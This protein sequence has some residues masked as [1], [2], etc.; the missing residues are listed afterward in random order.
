MDKPVVAT[1]RKLPWMR[2]AVP[3]KREEATS[4]SKPKAAATS[5]NAA[6]TRAKRAKKKSKGKQDEEQEE[7]E[8]K[9]E[10]SSK[11]RGE[12]KEGEEDQDKEE[13]V[14]KKPAPKPSTKRPENMIK[15]IEGRAG[16]TTKPTAAAQVGGGRLKTMLNRRRNNLAA[17][18]KANEVEEEE[19]EEVEKAPA[20]GATTTTSSAGALEELPTQLDVPLLATSTQLD[21]LPTQV[22]HSPRRSSRG[23]A[24]TKRAKAEVVASRS[25]SLS[26]NPYHL[27][28]DQATQSDSPMPLLSASSSP[29][30]TP[31]RSPTTPSPQHSYLRHLD[32]PTQHDGG[33]P[34]SPWALS[35]VA[36]SSPSSPGTTGKRKRRA[37]KAKKAKAAL[38]SSSSTTTTGPTASQWRRLMSQA[39]Q[40]DLISSSPSLSQSQSQGDSSVAYDD[41]DAMLGQPTQTEDEVRCHISQSSDLLHR[42]TQSD[43]GGL[44]GGVSPIRLRSGGRGRNLGP[45]SPCASP[46]RKGW[47][48]DAGGLKPKGKALEEDTSLDTSLLLLDTSTQDDEV[49]L[50]DYV[51]GGAYEEDEDD[52][53]EDDASSSW[54]AAS[55]KNNAEKKEKKEKRKG[56]RP[57]SLDS[58]LM[59]PTQ[60]DPPSS[61]MRAPTQVDALNTSTQMDLS[62]FVLSDTEGESL[63]SIPT[64]ADLPAFNLLGSSGA[65]LPP[66]LTDDNPTQ[67]DSQPTQLDTS[68]GASS[69]ARLLEEQNTDKKRKKEKKEKTNSNKK[70]AIQ[71]TPTL[72]DALVY[73]PTPPLEFEDEESPGFGV[74]PAKSKK[75]KMVDEDEGTKREQ[76]AGAKRRSRGEERGHTTSEQGNKKTE[77]RSEHSSRSRPGAGDRQEEEEEEYGQFGKLVS[78]NPKFKSVAIPEDGVLMG[79]HSTC[80]PACRF[81]NT[82]IST[83]HCK[84]SVVQRRLLLASQGD[85]SNDTPSLELSPSDGAPECRYGVRCYRKNPQHLK[86]FKHPSFEVV[87]ED[88]STNG[89]Y[90]NEV[91]VGRGATQTLQEGQELS[92]V[93]G[94]TDRPTDAP[95][96]LIAYRYERK[97]T[98]T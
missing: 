17:V 21:E 8:M 60:E 89:T 96:E 29:L 32:S 81:K 46:M 23:R 47:R 22:D 93:L 49:Y 11:P 27:L 76:A 83:K 71:E 28:L 14:A 78:L 67:I 6:N 10:A 30:A 55:K 37:D 90:I 86:Q 25:P 39:T 75:R 51:K 45:P 79:R 97:S 13:E 15:A 26:P 19:E 41:L 1:T 92:L 4:K 42:P 35:P 95:F 12:E 54:K 36:P 43:D 64:Q 72:V 85:E 63:G 84:V 70:A 18:A 88:T 16:D 24:K 66:T 68:L 98:S 40:T 74:V 5:S 91:L 73:E 50:D 94:V 69:L 7:E 53:D 31:P 57:G 2:S 48:G 52:E 56:L 44:L 61:L 82:H 34:R 9:P 65:G 87:V 77:K 3:K 58:S 33:A 80:H 38:A 20:S 59:G 62:M